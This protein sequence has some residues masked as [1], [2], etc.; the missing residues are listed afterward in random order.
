MSDVERMYAPNGTVAH[1]VRPSWHPHVHPAAVCGLSGPRS[2]WWRGT[3]S[4]DEYER[5]EALPTC[6]TCERRDAR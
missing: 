6:K 2:W 3:G 5:A 4:Q 1:L